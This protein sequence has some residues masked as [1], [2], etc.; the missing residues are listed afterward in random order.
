MV[1]FSISTSTLL[2]KHRKRHNIFQATLPNNIQTPKNLLT[3]PQVP[4]GTITTSSLSHFLPLTPN[5]TAPDNE[6][7]YKDIIGEVASIVA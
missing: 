6:T 2:S 7:S 3:N 4:K 1:N 5:Q